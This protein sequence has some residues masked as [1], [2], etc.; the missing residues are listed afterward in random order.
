MV[1]VDYIPSSPNQSNKKQCKHPEHHPPSMIVLKPGIHTWR[2]PSC[3]EETRVK[4]LEI[5][6]DSKITEENIRNELRNNLNRQKVAAQLGVLNQWEKCEWEVG[7]GFKYNTHY[8]E[9]GVCK[10]G[11][12][13]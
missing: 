10:C 3:K 12:I 11:K 8:Y 1:F 6:M 9:N 13:L 5:D 4:I 2:C 7:E